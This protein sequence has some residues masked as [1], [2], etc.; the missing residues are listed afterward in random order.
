[1]N[2][3]LGIDIGGSGIKG[4]LVDLDKGALASARLRIETPN[5]STPANV[6]AAVGAIADHFAKGLG[7]GP[8]GLTVPAPIVHGS[9]PMMVNL[10]QR[11]KG[12][13]ARDYF[14]SRLGRPV[15]PINDADAAG[16]AEA[17]YGAA[18]NEKGVVIVTTLG[19]GIGAAILNDGVLLP[20]TE[21]GH[22]EI[23]G[24]DAES[25]ASAA[26]MEKHHLT[27]KRWAKRLQAYYATL[28]R[29]FWPNLFV[30]G[31]GISRN[32]D[33]FLPLLDLNTPIVPAALRNEA[34]SIGAALAARE[35]TEAPRTVRIEQPVPLA[36]AG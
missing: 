27:Y 22:L 2:L 1:M 6:A 35:T 33:K 13:K 21:L 11:W 5:K 3:L 34:G 36:Q 30:V 23:K 7:D 8:I 18:R 24:K 4:A 15:I 16:L 19:T 12:L 32:H 25:Q 29:L 17:R 26:Y 28:E 31:G 9:V 10:D 20:N 14:S